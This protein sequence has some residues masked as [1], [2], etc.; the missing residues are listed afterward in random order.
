MHWLTV[1]VFDAELPATAWLRAWHDVLVET[2]LSS[3]AVF[4]DDH[5]QP[6]GVV[7]E[8]TFDDEVARDRFRVHPTLLAALDATPDPVNGTLVYPH[9]GGG[10]GGRVPRRPRT[11]P[12]ADAIALARPEAVRCTTLIGDYIPPLD[13]LTTSAA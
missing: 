8:F 9:R 7:V 6:W 4:W 2:A 3:G 11:S 12:S 1:E 13:S 5:E 10:A